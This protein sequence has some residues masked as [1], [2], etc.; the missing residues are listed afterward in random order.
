MS[1]ALEFTNLL[2]ELDRRLECPP[3]LELLE[4]RQPALVLVQLRLQQ[5]LRP[6]LH[7]QRVCTGEALH[8]TLPM[9]RYR[10]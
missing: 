7:R 4:L 3:S 6:L 2:I 8:C 10:Q 1:P 9:E 5:H